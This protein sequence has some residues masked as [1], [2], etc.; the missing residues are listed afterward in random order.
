MRT[1]PANVLI[2]EKC[3]VT[4]GKAFPFG[5]SGSAINRQAPET[6]YSGGRK[7]CSPLTPLHPHPYSVLPSPS[8][9]HP[10]PSPPIPLPPSPTNQASNHHHLLLLLLLLLSHICLLTWYTALYSESLNK[11]EQ[12]RG[13]RRRKSQ[14]FGRL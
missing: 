5:C 4:L 6:N 11:S 12:K 14:Y 7:L 2:T 9:P 13:V 8:H 1:R 10:S 3:R